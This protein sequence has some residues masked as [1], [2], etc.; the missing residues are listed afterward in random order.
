[1][2]QRQRVCSTFVSSSILCKY[3]VLLNSTRA[4]LIFQSLVGCL[5]G[6][7]GTN[8]RRLRWRLE[9]CE[10]TWHES[11]Y[12]SLLYHPFAF[13]ALS[14]FAITLLIISTIFWILLDTHSTSLLFLIMFMNTIKNNNELINIDPQTTACHFW[15]Q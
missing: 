15:A 3:I 2:D 1:M 12:V 8:E 13:I 11:M 14:S 7:Y 6:G 4:S 5:M 10:N 9:T